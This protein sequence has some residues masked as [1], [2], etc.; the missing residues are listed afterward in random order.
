MNQNELPVIVCSGTPREMGR[1]YGE[2][3]A[4]MI[5]HNLEQF[6]IRRD[7]SMLDAM[8][9]TLQEYAP[10]VLEELQGM[11]EGSGVEFELLLSYNH[12]E[13][14]SD[15]QDRCTV[16]AVQSEDAGLLIAK[17]NDSGAEEDSRFLIRKGQCGSGL[18]FMQLTYAG[19]L[20]GLDMVNAAGLC[21]THGSVGSC[22]ARTGNRLDIRLHLY[23]LLQSCRCVDELISKL[24][25]IPLT[26]KGFSIAVGDAEGNSVL[27]DAAVPF[28]AER[29]RNR[30]FAYS[31]NLYE[32]PGLEN[33]DMRPA[34]GR[35]ICLWRNGYLKWVENQNP[36]RTLAQLQKLAASHEPWAPCRHGGIQRS[37]TDWSVIFQ[38][39]QGKVLVA[40]GHP[41]EKPYQ[42]IT[43]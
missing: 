31:T 34:S 38:P 24:R 26:G 17:N 20:S 14:N 1:Q 25:S 12:W 37:T 15:D 9:K 22:F 16:F 4:D 6:A 8:Q 35:N 19:F 2:Q 32:Y 27:L 23:Q 43:L 36:P 18:P 13:L 5:R 21:N 11:A 41:C 3:A 40:H 28:I 29:S 33:A 39:Q 30:Q 7:R 42:E 10:A